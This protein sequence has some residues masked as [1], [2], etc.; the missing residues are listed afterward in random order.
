MN[1]RNKYI[2]AFGL[3]CAAAASFVCSAYNNLALSANKN[4]AGEL[5][6]PVIVN[7]EAEKPYTGNY[8]VIAEPGGRVYDLAPAD[9]TENDLPNA[10]VFTEI[11]N[12]FIQELFVKY[13][14][15]QGLQDAA[16]PLDN[17]T[18]FIGNKT[19]YY[20]KSEAAA[21]EQT[22]AESGVLLRLPVTPYAKSL[23]KPWINWYGDLNFALR[24]LIVFL[25]DP[26]SF[27]FCSLCIVLFVILLW[28]EIK[29]GA[30]GII[31]KHGKSVE[32]IVLFLLLVFALLLRVD[33]LTRH[34]A[35]AD[36]LYS[37]VR[38]AS[39]HVPWMNTFR[40][41]GNPPLFYLL[42]RI[43]YEI[44]GWSEAS[45]RML[46][47]VIGVAGI[48]SLYCFVKMMCGRKCA[49]LAAFLLTINPTHIGFSNEMRAYILMMTL[50]PLAAGLFFALLRKDTPQRYALY[51][52]AGAALVN[53]H[54]YGVLL[55]VFNAVWYAIR[56]RKKLCSKKTLCFL[57]AN[58]LIALSLLPFFAI[59]AFQRALTNSGFNTWIP[60]P[61]HW[62]FTRF[63]RLVSFCFLFFAAKK[64]SKTLANLSGQ[65]GAL[66]DY[67][68][69]VVSFIFV[70]VYVV[71]V[72]S[73]KR[74]I[75]N[76][77]YL[78]ICLP[79]V[80]SVPLAI[81][82]KLNYGEGT[83]FIRCIF[84]VTLIR[85]SL[86]FR[87]FW[88]GTNDV[89]K[90]VQEYISADI[91]AHSLKTAVLYTYGDSRDPSYYHLPRTDVYLHNNII[92]ISWQNIYHG[93]DYEVVYIN[94]FHVWGVDDMSR[95]LRWAGLD[96]ENTL[97][98]RTTNGK[99]IYKKYLS[100]RSN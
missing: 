40:D 64:W 26:L 83:A 84:L 62:E 41:P 96:L 90:E 22:E 73:P 93:D 68:V 51:V 35:W 72:I 92:G 63:I 48:V 61:G 12:E 81:A 44:F 65:S 7:I 2:L 20:P 49:F 5:L 21:W 45:G 33:G 97:K 58:A 23:I 42:L 76:W 78:S 94:P 31:Q 79:F 80:F 47:V 32:I 82:L 46:C 16:G 74:S 19:F 53:T 38:A 95:M 86:D 52:L 10:V 85:F 37:S 54:Y 57:A 67:A 98:I 25:R 14:D 24:E 9:E 3:V 30:A 1:N 99:F 55:I 88:G 17:I 50:A 6:A 13:E 89:Y 29:T 39:P 69:C 34:S 77:R 56:G 4:T 11:H 66:L 27:W 15:R 18:V 36:E 71:S 60:K 100:A 8:C 87:M 43:W 91:A 59:T 28:A 75:F 70:A